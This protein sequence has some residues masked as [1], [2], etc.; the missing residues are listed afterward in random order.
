MKQ[1]TKCERFKDIIDFRKVRKD[2][3]KRRSICNRCHNKSKRVQNPKR[4]QNK[5]PHLT[6]NERVRNY[7][8]LSIYG[9]TLDQYNQLAKNQNYGCA[10]CGQ[11]ETLKHQTGVLRNLA[12][13]HNHSTGE[14]RG[15]LCD[16]HNRG[17]GLFQ[18]NVEYLKK[19][20]QYLENKKE[21]PASNEG[22]DP[23][24]TPGAL[25]TQP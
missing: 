19:A 15:L 21:P 2:S 6:K 4:P 20:I 7:E 10:I 1:C 23:Q 13:D 16:K 25:T 11:P 24:K 5:Y 8:Y 14:I 3:E 18:D 17:L 12:V 22:G 9:I